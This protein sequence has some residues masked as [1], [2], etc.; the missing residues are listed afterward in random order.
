MNQQVI[1]QETSHKHLGLIFSSD[2]N[3]HEHIDYV[4]T[5]AWS[6]IN[7]M[8]KLKF[9]LDRKSLET[10]YFSFIRPL[11]EYANVVW[12]NCTQY[13]SNELEKIQNEAARIVTGATKLASLHSLYADTGWE[14]LASR[15][16]KHKLILYYKM[17]HGMTPEYLSSLVPPTVGSTARYPL[18]N[19]SD[20][21]TVPAKSQQYFNSFLP[22]VT[23][24][25]NGL[26]EEI[27]NAETITTFKYKL[28]RNLNKPPAYY[29]SGTR[30][31]QI[32][33]TRFR[34]SCSSLHHHLFLKN[35]I[36]DPLCECGVIEDTNHFFFICDRF[37]NLRHVLLNTISIF[38]QPTLEVIL[39]G[40][41]D[42]S[43]E[44]N[45]QIFLAVHEFILKTKR[46]L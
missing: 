14:S 8:R 26:P 4:K 33:L 15:R 18:R 43:V 7:V 22:S 20:L 29:F 16:E 13:E 19:E 9:K 27:K 36:N 44:G 42:I 32:Y 37:R 2:C 12:N 23:R 46:F 45:K 5:K 39:Y 24:A 11:L 25:W 41:T 17:Q 30:L 28:N 10:I 31:G 1:N 34:L 38:C 40:S 3:W 21:Q 6:R 35:I